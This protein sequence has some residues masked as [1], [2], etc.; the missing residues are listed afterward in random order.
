MRLV[1]RSVPH[2]RL[3]RALTVNRTRTIAHCVLEE[4][5]KRVNVFT[6]LRLTEGL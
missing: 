6:S 2:P 3:T 5:D 1:M 4:E